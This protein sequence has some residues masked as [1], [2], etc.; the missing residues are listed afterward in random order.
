MVTI[1]TTYFNAQ[2]LCTFPTQRIYIFRKILTD[3]ILHKPT[4]KSVTRIKNKKFRTMGSVAITVI[5]VNKQ[6]NVAP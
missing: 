6:Q 4:R 1:C 3:S 5:Q 2:E